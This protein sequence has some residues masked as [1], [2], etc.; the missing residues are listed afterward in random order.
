[1]HELDTQ[2]VWFADRIHSHSVTLDL[3]YRNFACFQDSR[4]TLHVHERT[5]YHVEYTVLCIMPLEF[6]QTRTHT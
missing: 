4:M 1:M 6:P 5:L 3:L 2:L